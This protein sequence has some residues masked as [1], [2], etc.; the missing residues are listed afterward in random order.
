MGHQARAAQ[1][2]TD[3]ITLEDVKSLTIWDWLAIL[4]AIS[5][6]GSAATAILTWNPQWLWITLITGILLG[7]GV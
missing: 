3:V 5:C 2:K 4:I 7:A 1:G 6:V